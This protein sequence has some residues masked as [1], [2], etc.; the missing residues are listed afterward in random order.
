V[1][2]VVDASV[3]VKWLLQDLSGEQDVPAALDILNGLVHERYEMIQPPHWIAEVLAVMARKQPQTTRSVLR[4]LEEVGSLYDIDDTIY[5]RAVE[6]AD[7]FKHHLFDTLYHAVA[8]EHGAIYVTAD[9][10][11]LKVASQEG[12]IATLKGFKRP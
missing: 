8:L 11:Y 2:P 1:K 6:L 5:V 10:R 7:R 12:A 9:E 3:A 4:L